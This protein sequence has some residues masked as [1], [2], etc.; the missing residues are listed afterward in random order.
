MEQNE[1]IRVTIDTTKLPASAVFTGQN[2][3]KYIAFDLME[4]RGGEDEYG[5]THA[6]SCWDKTSGQRIYV[7][8]GKTETFGQQAAPQNDDLPL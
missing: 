6:A 5:N 1:K 3:H 8:K 2:G 4:R 7:G